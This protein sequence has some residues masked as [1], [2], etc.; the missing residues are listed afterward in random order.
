[1]ILKNNHSRINVNKNNKRSKVIWLFA[2]SFITKSAALSISIVSFQLLFHYYHKSDI[3]NGNTPQTMSTSFLF[4]EIFVTG[5]LTTIFTL[6]DHLLSIYACRIKPYIFGLVLI[7]YGVLLSASLSQFIY[8]DHFITQDSLMMVFINP[9]DIILHGIHFHHNALYYF[10]TTLVAACLLFFAIMRLESNRLSRKIVFVINGSFMVALL[11]SYSQSWP[12]SLVPINAPIP[13]NDENTGSITSW[14]DVLTNTFLNKTGLNIS[15]FA[16]FIVD[17]N[18]TIQDID[19][20]NIVLKQQ[21]TLEEYTDFASDYNTTEWN[22][23]FIIIESL[24]TGIIEPGSDY[25]FVMPCISGIAQESVVFT[26]HYSTASHSNYADISP[27]SS[28]WPLRD[29]S[30]HVYP[31]KP[32][33]PRVLIYDILGKLGYSTSIV[34][35]QNESWGKMANYLKT[36][37]LDILLDSRNFNGNIRKN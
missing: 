22:V 18:E 28:H 37:N 21:L 26:N 2:H 8:T 7:T 1:M 6:S 36:D 10:F 5:V 12:L 16:S 13:Y 19:E 11:V 23:V 29:T 30:T 33:Y 27:L 15:F 31:E 14:G 20:N 25:L 34:S 17:S 24:R 4:S 32:T 35:S 9:K 3:I